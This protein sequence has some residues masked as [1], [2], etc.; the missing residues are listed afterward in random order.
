MYVYMCIYMCIYVYIYV[1]IC[2]YI[3]VYMC[4]FLCVCIYIYIYC[5][6]VCVYINTHILIIIIIMHIL[7]L[8]NKYFKLFCE[9]SI[10]I[11]LQNKWGFFL[12]VYIIAVV[13]KYNK[14]KQISVLSIYDWTK[15]KAKKNQPIY[16]YII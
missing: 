4:I 13:E 12:S 10:K 7:P 16:I 9:N 5:V 2:V 14:T 8:K 1:Y 15:R 6:C 3:C 11:V